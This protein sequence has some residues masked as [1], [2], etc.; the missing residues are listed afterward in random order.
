MYI[1]T[2]NVCRKAILS[3]G[4]R[5]SSTGLAIFNR[6]DKPLKKYT[7]SELS[8]SSFA[9]AEDLTDAVIVEF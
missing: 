7:P 1:H 3:S 9:D 6:I 5:E 8:L 2:L 4:D